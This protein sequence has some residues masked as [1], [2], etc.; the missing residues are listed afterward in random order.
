MPIEVFSENLQQVRPLPYI[1]TLRK[2]ATSFLRETVAMRRI[3]RLCTVLHIIWG[4]EGNYVGMSS[5]S[6]TVRACC[7]GVQNQGSYHETPSLETEVENRQ[8]PEAL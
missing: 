2:V 6:R 4:C 1:C 8:I 7:Y 5:T 3:L